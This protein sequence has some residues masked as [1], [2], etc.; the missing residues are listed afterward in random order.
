MD[1]PDKKDVVNVDG[2]EFVKS[3]A[4]ASVKCKNPFVGKTEPE[5]TADKIEYKCMV[6]GGKRE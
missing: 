1:S 5:R 2:K 6:R 4:T 3:G